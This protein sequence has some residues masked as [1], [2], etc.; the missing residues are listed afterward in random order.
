MDCATDAILKLHLNGARNF[1]LDKQSK[2]LGDG[3]EASVVEKLHAYLSKVARHVALTALARNKPASVSLDSSRGSDHTIDPP[4]QSQE[5]PTDT[6]TIE[7]LV[8]KIKILH[9]PLER[10][11]LGLRYRGGFNYAQ[12]A[13]MLFMTSE[14]VARL[15]QR[16]IQTLS[17]M[18]GEN[19]E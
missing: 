9:D 3:S 16:A 15:C 4:E 10:A 7:R 12:I 1:Y 5:P 14:R 17:R 2:A 11:I 18:M 13:D 8:E 19:H 6:E